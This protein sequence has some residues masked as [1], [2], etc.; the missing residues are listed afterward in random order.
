MATFTT[1]EK[2]KFQKKCCFLSSEILGSTMQH[3]NIIIVVS[4][5]ILEIYP[6]ELQQLERMSQPKLCQ[7]AMDA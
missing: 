1:C 3:N 5:Y 7:Y 6:G 4:K 2:F